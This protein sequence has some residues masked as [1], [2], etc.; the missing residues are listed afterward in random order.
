MSIE[1]KSKEQTEVISINL[2]DES[3]HIITICP[4][5]TYELAVV[6]F[7]A[8]AAIS[9]ITIIFLSNGINLPLLMLAVIPF[10]LLRKTNFRDRFQI[11]H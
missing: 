8:L 7:I 4:N 1:I 11:Q 10:L 6:F 2:K 3:N 9:T 5:I